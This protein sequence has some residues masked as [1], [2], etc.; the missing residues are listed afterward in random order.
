[1]ASPLQIIKDRFGS[2]EALVD[3]VLPLLDRN[4][5]ET[6]TDF[7]ERLLRVSNNK[8]LRL[9]EQEETLRRDFGTRAAL[10]DKL[11]LLSTGGLMDADL[12]KRLAQQSTGRLLG[13]YS[14]LARKNK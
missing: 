5:G 12:N 2:K 7:R 10:A 4:E 9:L 8:L 6:D 13:R 14:V 1:M 3:K 11:T